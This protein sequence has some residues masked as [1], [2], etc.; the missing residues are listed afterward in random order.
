MERRRA[1]DR[2]RPA[3]APVDRV[4]QNGQSSVHRSDRLRRR[5]LTLEIFD[6]IDLLEREHRQRSERRFQYTD[7][8]ANR[9]D[10]PQRFRDHIP[11]QIQV[12]K[13]CDCDAHRCRWCWRFS[14]ILSGDDFT[15]ELRFPNLLRF[16]LRTHRLRGAAVQRERVDRHP[17][18]TP[19]CRMSSPNARG[20][21]VCG[22]PSAPARGTLC[23][24]CSGIPRSWWRPGFSSASPP[25]LPRRVC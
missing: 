16:L 22:W 3:A 10:T 19:S 17:V 8:A 5:V 21:S 4:S 12:E 25:L 13:L 1:E 6:R 14:G 11:I 2:R 15:D 18:P 24:A 20:R 9:R 7:P 23:E